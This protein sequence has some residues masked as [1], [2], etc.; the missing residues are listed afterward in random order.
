MGS[1][2]QVRLSWGRLPFAPP[3]HVSRPLSRSHPLSLQGGLSYLPYGNGRSY[4]DACLNPAQGL[5]DA[6]GLDRFIDWD[7]E[8]GRLTCEAGVLLAD[9]IR[10][11][12]PQ[13]WFLPV[14]PG[15]Q[16]VT[17][18]GAIANDVHGKNHHVEGSFGHHV[19]SFELLRSDGSRLHVDRANSPQ[20]LAATTGGLG[21]TGLIVAATLKLKR[22][23]GAMI[24]QT[25]RRF[26]ALDEFFEVDAALRGQHDYTVAWID[27]IAP[28]RQRGRGLY[29]AGNFAAA[30][31]APK[32]AR[33][34]LSVPIEPPLSL[35]GSASLRAFNIAY[36]H[37]P[38]PAAV[39]LVDPEEFF[40][41]LDRVGDW[42][43]IYGP[44]G[45]YQFQCVLPPA[46]MREALGQLLELIAQRQTGSFLVVLKT[47][48]S[49]PSEG[50]LSFA[51][52][53]ATLALDFPN[54]GEATRRL[55]TELEAAVLAA[56][57]ALYPAKDALMSAAAFRAGYPRWR[58]M[59]P[60]VDPAF[61]SRFWR[62]VA[63]DS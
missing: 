4:G 11:L 44:R 28:A 53:G 41:P 31:A 57:G 23:A 10:L 27:C 22:V 8:H 35:I 18:G 2:A 54:G 39:H 50:L 45:F 1:S 37:L 30:S 14:V 24:A 16:F 52:P 48:G 3:A 26:R 19:E 42:N 34:G 12:L 49:R 13:G 59:L 15:T 46:T 63:V 47:F 21:L 60:F 62:R 36:F 61:S 51:R 29:M 32:R 20:W 6:R 56:G 58:E 40:F 55:F 17:V 43:R 33:S 38:R 7:A 9:I 25:L 5:I